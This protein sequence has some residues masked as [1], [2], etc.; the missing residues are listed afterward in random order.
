[1]LLYIW[2]EINYTREALQL[3][4]LSMNNLLKTYNKM[5]R[6]LLQGSYTF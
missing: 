2:D 5:V 4:T 1:M 6:I 3:P